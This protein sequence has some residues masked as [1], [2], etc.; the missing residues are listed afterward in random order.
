MIDH[1]AFQEIIDE[2]VSKAMKEMT[3]DERL[4][5]EKHI[6]ASIRFAVIATLGYSIRVGEYRPLRPIEGTPIDAMLELMPAPARERCRQ[7]FW[8]EGIL[9]VEDFSRRPDSGW[10]KT[11]NFGKRCLA[12]AREAAS[13]LRLG[14]HAT[15]P[16]LSSKNV[17]S[18][19]N[20]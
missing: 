15:L 2:A 18:E 9:T 5:L 12:Q 1:P 3:V 7:V 11:P 14:H 17:C 20:P 19:P 16:R 4:R 13:S 8:E 6:T 10:L